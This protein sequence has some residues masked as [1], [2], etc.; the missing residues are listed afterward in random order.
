[1]SLNEIYLVSQIAAAVLV[2]PTVLYLALQ[3]RQNTSQMRAN[4]THQYLQ[5]AK[6]LN[7]ALIANKQAASVY[8]RGVNSFDSLDD[9]EKTQFFFYAGQFYQSFS[10]MYVLWREKTLPDSAWHPIRKHLVSMMAMPGLR[11][12]WDSWAREGLAPEFVA[13]VDALATST[14]PT[15]SLNRSLSGR[16]ESAAGADEFECE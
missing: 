2:A 16:D 1:M 3:V 11:H 4:A 8:R 6:D 14:E 15:Y 13:Y 7:L 5:T 10:D 12:V 9:D